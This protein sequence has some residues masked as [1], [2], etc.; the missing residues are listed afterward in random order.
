MLLKIKLHP[1][2]VT[3]SDGVR[4][5]FTRYLLSNIRQTLQNFEL[6]C[7]ITNNWDHLLVRAKCDPSLYPVFIQIIRQI[8]GIQSILKIKQIDFTDLH[9][10]FLAVLELNQQRL[11]DKTFAVRVKRKG[12]HHEFS[13]IDAERYIGGGLRQHVAG[14]KVK[15]TNPDEIVYVEIINEK[16]NLIEAIYNGLGGFP[17]GSQD[18]VLSL[19]SGGY[20]SAVSSFQMIRRGLKTHYLFFNLGGKEHVYHVK[21]IVRKVWQNYSSSHN[22]KFINVDFYPIMLN[23]SNYVSDGYTGVVLKRMFYRVANEIAQRLHIDGIVTGEALGQVSSQTLKNLKV[24]EKVIDVPLLRPL[25][26]YDKDEIIAIARQIG[27]AEL[28][29]QVQEFCGVM[30]KKPTIAAIEETLLAEEAKLDI[31]S[32]VTQALDTAEIENLR[33]IAK[34]D[35]IDVTATQL[36]YITTLDSNDIVIDVRDNPTFEASKIVWSVPV[37]NIPFYDLAEKFAELDQTKRYALYC[38]KGLLSR[39]QAINLIEAGYQ[40]V[41]VISKDF[42]LLG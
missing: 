17:L 6:G 16:A 22:V 39:L 33:D 36:T 24:I 26:A 32:L 29:A 10:L 15:L 41:V 34:Q 28:S 35:L 23:I 2:I 4:K 14:S 37:I 9:Q 19:I 8:P 25:I 38:T 11:V 27:T 21:K 30:G 20:D 18:Q 42:Q 31:T 13:S 1:E 40:N 3:K 7:A 5:R 12:N